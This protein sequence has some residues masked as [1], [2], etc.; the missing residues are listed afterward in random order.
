MA[1]EVQRS[2]LSLQ[3]LLL[4]AAGT[5]IA[6][7]CYLGW[8]RF[9]DP[10]TPMTSQRLVDLIVR[11]VPPGEPLMIVVRDVCMRESAEATVVRILDGGRGELHLTPVTD[12]LAD[13]CYRRG[14][15]VPLPPM[16]RP[17][18]WTLKVGYRWCNI[19]DRCVTDWF[20][21]VEMDVAHSGYGLYLRGWREVNPAAPSSEEAK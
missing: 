7:I 6:T 17:G 8:L 9:L 20:P 19:V 13:G 14:R 10:V 1:P 11:D 12:V 3:C 5:V 4:L 2:L 16:L 15:P 18:R 21:P